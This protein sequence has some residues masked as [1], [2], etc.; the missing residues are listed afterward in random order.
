MTMMALSLFLMAAGGDQ[1]P[2]EYASLQDQQRT[3]RG[4]VEV[5]KREQDYLL[6]QQAMYRADSKYLIIDIKSRTGQLK[7]K[8]RALKD[9]RFR[10]SKSFPGG[11]LR[12]GMLKFTKKVEGR[13][14]RHALVFGKSLMVQW[15]PATVRQKEADIPVITLTRKDLLS[16]FYAVEEGSLAYLVP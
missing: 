15:K 2:D 14:D 4:R 3:L 11:S 6:F 8:N 1:K 7:Y 13:N 16:V 12:T 10:T 9:F 5:L